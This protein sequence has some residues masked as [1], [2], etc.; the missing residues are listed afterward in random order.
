MSVGPVE[1]VLIE[2]PEGWLPAEVGARIGDLVEAGT[3]RLVDALVVSKSADGA[4]EGVELEESDG[5]L[6]SL[7]GDLAQDLDLLAEEDV[8]ALAEDLAPGTTALALAFE[9]SWMVPVRDAVLA[10]G[11]SLVADIHVPAEVVAE[12]AAAVG[13]A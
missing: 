8:D 12:V 4:V 3:V 10:S 7:F 13:P 1:I 2:F 9:H 6:S 5:E 11:G